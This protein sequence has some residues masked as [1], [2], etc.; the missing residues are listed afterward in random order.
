[1][2][3]V[4]ALD[5]TYAGDV[6]T[7]VTI[8]I[9]GVNSTGGTTPVSH[10]VTT[11]GTSV[12]APPASGPVINTESFHVWHSNELNTDT[13]TG[14]SVVDTDSGA[15]T[16]DF[17]ITAVTAHDPDSSVD[18]GTACGYLDD[19]NSALADGL[20]YNP[21]AVPPA[22]DQITLTVTDKTTGLFDTVHFI[23]NEAGNTSQG[24][25]LQGTSGKDVI[26]ATDTGDT[27]TGGGGKDQFVFSPG[28]IGYDQDGHPVTNFSHTIIDF[29]TG[30]DKIDLRQFSDIGSVGN[31]VIAPQQDSDDTLVTWQQQVTSP[32]GASI[33]EHESLLLKNVI[34]ANL[35]GS[36]FIFHVT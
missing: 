11:I 24:I 10:D 21:G 20:T 32:E 14:L 31:L 36:D 23:F 15:A 28:S 35:K 2:L 16:D 22:D 8:D 17:K 19:I 25:T 26:F 30:L 4:H 33:T 6:T 29:T 9:S 3:G 12:T 5:D 27:L 13:V 34:A 1:M 18:P 7:P